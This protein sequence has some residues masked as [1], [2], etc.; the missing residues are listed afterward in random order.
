M[1]IDITDFVKNRDPW[2]YS[3]SDFENGNDR[4]GPETWKAAQDLAAR[5]PMLSTPDQLEA[6]RQWIK[7]TGAWPDEYATM[8]DDD[9]NALF[10]QLVSGDLRE[11]G[12]EGIDPSDFDWE[13]YQAD[14]ESG[15]ISGSIYQCEDK[16]IIYSLS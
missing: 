9:L 14:E 1:E 12:L 15:R 2:E 16:S 10:I 11:M 4:A 5:E 6:M 8:S 3:R 7:D 13:S